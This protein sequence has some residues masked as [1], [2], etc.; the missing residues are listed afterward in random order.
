MEKDQVFA[1][2]KFRI[3]PFEFN[4]EVTNVFDDMLNRSV[5]F[6]MESIKRQSQLTAEYY[7][8]GSRIYDLGCSHGNVGMLILNQLKHRKFSM[9]AVDSSK[10]M[11]EKYLKR[12]GK[13]DSTPQIEL[14]CGFL[15]DIQI[16]KASVVLI[17]LTL[18]FL[19]KEKRDDLIKK[20]YQGMNPNG[21]L[22]LT[23]KTVHTSKVLDDLQTKFYKTFKLENGYSQLEISQKRDALEKVLIPDTI[24]THKNR[25]L[26]TGFTTFD[27]WLKWFNFAS[28][29]AIKK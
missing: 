12:L 26:N 25:I 19:D 17:N 24:E 28:M 13:H 22:L 3:K 9:V 15:E 1:D 10:P 20:I 4:E 11:I 7:Q 6:Y 5:P 14:V 27:V 2:K 29:I 18:Q 16:K 21:I 8:E 23:E